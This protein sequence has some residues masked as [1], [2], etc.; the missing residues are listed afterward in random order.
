MLT[1]GCGL[2]VVSSVS[3]AMT[4]GPFEIGDCVVSLSSS[5]QGPPLGLRGLVRCS[6]N[7]QDLAFL[8]EQT[9]APH[10][11]LTM[12]CCLTGGLLCRL[13]ASMM[14]HA[15]CCLMRSFQGAMTCRAGMNS[16]ELPQPEL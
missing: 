14:R 3:A 4:D 7:L 12:T 1:G 15:R 13:W 10:K 8:R 16:S 2:Q 5:S 11:A 9:R 6:L